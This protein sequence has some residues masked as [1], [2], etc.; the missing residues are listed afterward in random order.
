M[1]HA[2]PIYYEE[3]GPENG[4]PLI[5]SSGLG[6]SAGYWAPNLM[7]LADRY[8]VIAYDHRGTGR[9]E[10]EIEGDLTIEAMADDL[11]GLM[12]ALGIPR[13]TLVG[14]AIGGM[15]GLAL[16]LKSPWRLPR[17]VVING[18]AKLDPHTARC[19][20]TRLVLLRQGP[21]AYLHGQPIF[22]YPAQW[23]SEHDAELLREEEVQ[24]AHF[25]G[26][27][28]IGRRIAA[29]RRFNIANRLGRI[30]AK[31]LLVATQDDMLVPITCSE[32]LAKG[33]PGA[34][35]ARMIS[36]GHAVNVTR[37]DEFN[38]WLLGWLD[39]E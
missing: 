21:R 30:A 23:I 17:I 39:S 28:M 38:M 16:A 25:P 1:P 6:G 27:E 15:I 22:L 13:A 18:W 19:F 7:T 37:A 24:L 31:T 2:G 9:S 11:E 10:R 3:Y 20:D 26:A 35:V 8:R 34:K 29:A 36:G 14:H 5:L 12:D 4:E 33:I 32:A